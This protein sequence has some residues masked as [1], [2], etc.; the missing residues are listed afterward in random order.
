MS[1]DELVETAGILFVTKEA[2]KGET[3]EEETEYTR[4]RRSINI[5][6]EVSRSTRTSL[7][8]SKHYPP[9]VCIFLLY[10]SG[11][12]GHKASA[13]A[14][15]YLCKK[16]Y[17]QWKVLT[18]NVSE[19]AGCEFGDR[20]YNYILQQDLS[21]MVGILYSVAQKFGPFLSDKFT[22]T[23]KKE[24]KNLP[25]PDI[26]VSFVPFLNVS[27]MKSAPYAKHVTVMTDFTNT[28]AH[29]W[30]QDLKQ[31]VF[32]GTREAFEQAL[33][34]GYSSARLKLL[35]GMVVHPHFYSKSLSSNGKQPLDYLY[36]FRFDVSYPTFLL[37]FGAFP[38]FESTLRLISALSLRG[39]NCTTADNVDRKDKNASDQLLMER[40]LKMMEAVNVICVCGKNSRLLNS[41]NK[42]FCKSDGFR[43]HA[44]GFT[45]QVPLLMRISELVIS[46]PGPGVVA[47]ALVSRKPLMLLADERNLMEQ[48][49]AVADW[50]RRHGVGKVVNSIEAAASISFEEIT[51]LKRNVDA[52]PENCAVFEVVEELAKMIKPAD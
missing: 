13:D 18:L 36:E 45:D 32:C 49:K 17:P 34:K 51:H 7:E 1:G 3:D 10:G 14:V 31:T 12:G 25:K 40:V 24:W 37:I 43:I 38:P 23:L 44:V 50:V 15:E 20:L 26:I 42:K 46:K 8:Q 52:L 22:V 28:A 16:T 48:E 19:L 33:S 5:P 47:E 30:L 27:I 21:R 41:I 35:S 4:R 11:G 6:S 29:P 9:S 39:T 2:R